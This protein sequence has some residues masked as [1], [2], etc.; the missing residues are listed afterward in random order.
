MAL[1]HRRRPHQVETALPINSV[2][3]SY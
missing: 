2:E 3:S 1:Q